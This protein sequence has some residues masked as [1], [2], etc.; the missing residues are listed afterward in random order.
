MLCLASPG[1]SEGVGK[2]QVTPELARTSYPQGNSAGC[3]RGGTDVTQNVLSCFLLWSPGFGTLV[4]NPA[5]I[6]DAPR[7]SQCLIPERYPPTSTG[8]LSQL[9]RIPLCGALASEVLVGEPPSTC[10]STIHLPIH[11]SSHQGFNGLSPFTSR[12]VRQSGPRCTHL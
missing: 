4:P 3:V 11:L 8:V 2:R 6:S 9:Q 5:V 7:V 1:E 10:P 12:Q